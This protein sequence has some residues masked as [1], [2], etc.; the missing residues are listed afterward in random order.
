MPMLDVPANHRALVLSLL[1][2]RLPHCTAMAFGSRVSGWP[3]GVAAKPYSD[4]DV[5][6]WGLLPSDD[7][8]LAHLRA[9][10]EE[11]PLPWRVD[12]SKAQDLPDALRGDVLS[13][14]ALLSGNMKQLALAA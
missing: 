7:P 5:A 11:S 2:R 1:Q 12:L 9:D 8:A 6:L 13:H 10:L 4:L 3:G 14:G